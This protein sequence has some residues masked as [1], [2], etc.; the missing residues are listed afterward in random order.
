MPATSLSVQQAPARPPPGGQITGRCIGPLGQ[1]RE[2]RWR[3]RRSRGGLLVWALGALA[4]LNRVPFDPALILQQF[5][6]PYRLETLHEAATSLGFKVGF[7]RVKAPELSRLS[8]PCLA[9]LN[10]RVVDQAAP[11]QRIPVDDPKVTPLNPPTRGSEHAAKPTVP[12]HR[13]ALIVK[14]DEG[15][16]SFFEAGNP[17]LQSAEVR[18]FAD[19]F[20]GQ[21]LLFMRRQTSPN[22]HQGEVEKARKSQSGR[23]YYRLASKRTPELSSTSL[24]PVSRNPEPKGVS[25]EHGRR[26]KQWR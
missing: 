14:A 24:P 18:A 23:F 4:Q 15:A 26:P 20:S 25:S 9:V 8:F 22:K 7:N 1:T 19:Q 5:A 3:R 13:L 2:R 10:P 11:T 12:L 21:V 16:V 17:N 6:P